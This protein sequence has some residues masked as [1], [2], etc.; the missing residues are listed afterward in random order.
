MLDK[1]KPDGQQILESSRNPGVTRLSLGFG[2]V[3]TIAE[4]LLGAA[5][6][7]LR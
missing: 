4:R 5:G 1:D 2:T 6:G 7:K 3:G